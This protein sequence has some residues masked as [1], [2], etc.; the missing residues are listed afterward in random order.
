MKGSD[1]YIITQTLHTQIQQDYNV[2]NISAK[3]LISKDFSR[4]FKEFP[5]AFAKSDQFTI[6]EYKWA[7]GTIWSRS[8]DVKHRSNVIR[9]IPPFADMFNHNS[10]INTT[11]QIKSK[12]LE[13]VTH[14][15]VQ[16]GQQVLNKRIVFVISK[17]CLLITE[18]FQTINY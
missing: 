7:L 4:L 15:E 9:V 18:R 12:R 2:S 8:F 11:H 6:E 5:S 1:L 10:T 17:R 16:K 13:A 3:I 14:V